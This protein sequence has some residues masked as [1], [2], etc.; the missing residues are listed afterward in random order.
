MTASAPT[1]RDPQARP[2]VFVHIGEAKTGT[3]YLQNLLTDNRNALRADGLL[4]PPCGGSG[5]VHETFDLRGITFKGSPD[6]NIPGSWKRMVAAIGEWGGPALI[7]SELLAPAAPNHINRL[8]RSLDFADVHIVFT[9][10]DLARQLPAAWQE[11][12]KNRG[13]ETFAEWLALLHEPKTVANHAGRHFW[14]LHDVPAIL[15][16]W[17]EG[18][19][20]D[21]THVVT[22]PPSGGDPDL[23]WMRFAQVIGVDPT[24]FKQP[25]RSVNSSLGAAEVSLVRQVNAAL[26]GDDFPWPPYDRYMKWY[27]SPQL[28]TR[29]GATIDLPEHDYEWAVSMSQQTAKAIADAGYDVVGDLGE[30]TPSR[31]PTGMNPDEAP[32]ETVAAAGVD[33]IA[34]LVRLLADGAGADEVPAL[35]ARAE[36]AE[37]KLRE[38]AE[39][40]PIERIKRCV[41]ELS[42]QIRWLGAARS[43]YRRLRRRPPATQ[44]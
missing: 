33:G 36:A 31:R 34:S 42:D 14:N 35:R 17:S 4:Y 21:R 6:P 26:G 1:R 19:P 18:L 10:R 7:S 13:R 30:L 43:W 12:I 8:R 11:R 20:P 28:A 41:V 15:T 44:A 9:V 38:H 3:T 40:P 16:K 22:V 27:F 39:L 32:A 37:T 29:R 25:D 2:A 5:H 24:H 23:L